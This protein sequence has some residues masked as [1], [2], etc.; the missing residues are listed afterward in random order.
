MGVRHLETKKLPRFN[1]G[2]ELLENSGYAFVI[3]SVFVSSF[4]PLSTFFLS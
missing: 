1:T 3:K 2:A 4:R